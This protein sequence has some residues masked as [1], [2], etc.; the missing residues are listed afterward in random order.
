MSCVD[1]QKKEFQVD[2]AAS[3]KALRQKWACFVEEHKA[4]NTAGTE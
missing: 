4:A 1:F 3:A 2:K